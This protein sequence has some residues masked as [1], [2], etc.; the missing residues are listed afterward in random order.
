MSQSPLIPVLLNGITN[1]FKMEEPVWVD[2]DL[3]EDDILF[4]KGECEKPSQFDPNNR[5]KVLFD[6]FIDRSAT[7][8]IK[9][10]EYGKVFCILERKGQIDEIPW[11]LWGR[12]L[13]LYSQKNKPFR[14]FL[15]ADETLRKFP[16]RGP[17][18]PNNI[19]GGYTYACNR[20]SIVIYRAEDATRVL[21]HEL[22]HSCCLDKMENGVD[23]VEAETEA[24][25]ELIYIGLL[26]EGKSYIFKSL[27]QRQSEYMRK[28]NERII[29]EYGISDENKDF[30]WRYTLGKQRVW[31][32]WGI[33]IE[34]NMKP[35][36]R[37]QSLR[38][39]Y[40]PDNNLKDRF[41]VS[42]ASIIL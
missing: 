11:G 42:R 37:I 27:L 3:I 12:I 25:A 33:L 24:W 22:M 15:L 2:A 8:C 36:I 20:R 26:S 41:K 5:R 14:V 7:L 18:K 23:L 34:D 35:Y 4:L 31:E 9:N 10:C 17:I 32:R 40:P 19:N 29:A 30:P 13:R 6:K 1:D 39:T 16:K 38:M 21:L 28:Q